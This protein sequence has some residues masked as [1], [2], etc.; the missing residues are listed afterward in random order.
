MYAVWRQGE[1]TVGWEGP[2]PMDQW[3]QSWRRASEGDLAVI[4]T[5]F[6]GLSIHSGLWKKLSNN[7][8]FQATTIFP[9]VLSH[10]LP[11]PNLGT[12]CGVTMYSLSK[13]CSRALSTLSGEELAMRFIHSLGD[14]ACSPPFSFPVS[15][16]LFNLL[17][18]WSAVSNGFQDRVL[19]TVF[20]IK[21]SLKI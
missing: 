12:S 15:W 9:N 5:H 16:P 17:Q 11:F 10:S 14:A 4:S 21:S 1:G 7:H 8:T 20:L 3:H 6:W 19:I 18:R 2:L 13:V